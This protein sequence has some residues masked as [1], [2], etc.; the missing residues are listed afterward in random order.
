MGTWIELS[1]FLCS[2]IGML[3]TLFPL[4]GKFNQIAHLMNEIHKNYIIIYLCVTASLCI[5]FEGGGLFFSDIIVTFSQQKQC[6]KRQESL[7][8]K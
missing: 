4:H 5:K 8:S 6:L 3:Q 1:L 7:S 2:M